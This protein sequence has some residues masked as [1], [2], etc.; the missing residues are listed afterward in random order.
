[1]RRFLAVCLCCSWAA[2]AW[3][4]FDSATP[5]PAPAPAPAIV[6]PDTTGPIVQRWKAGVQLRAGAAPCGG[7]LGTVP[8][9]MEWPE[10]AVQ[11]LK[12]DVSPQIRELKY[13][14]LEE[15]VKQMVIAIP[16]LNPGEAASA[17]VT[18]EVTKQPIVPPED[19]SQFVIPARPPREVRRY[20]GS[21]PL[22]ETTKAEIRTKAK[23]VARDRELAWE[24]V[25]AIYEWVREHVEYK[26][27]PIKGAL[28][29][30][31]D[32]TGD[33]EELTSL[34]IAFCRVNGVPAR[35]VWVPGHCYPEFYLED[36]EG[37]G[38]WFPCQAA[39]TR[40]FG[41][42][43]ESRPILQKGDNFRVPEKK[44]PQRYV[45][46]FLT[47]KSQR[48]GGQPDHKFIGEIVAQ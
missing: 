41:G 30:M 20:L 46:E 45:A 19:T 27:G 15:G 29:A 7:I 2:P 34:F 13:R 36:R 6:T 3:C 43:V 26:D 14:T 17:V 16:L 4:Q 12:E 33:C 38:H 40:N 5:A 37:K 32:G 47:G 1:M 10:Q 23:E 44:E 22:I 9:P 31:R 48:G 25:E 8:V 24:K 39:G 11:I 42:M 21:S 28:A 35:T 18:F